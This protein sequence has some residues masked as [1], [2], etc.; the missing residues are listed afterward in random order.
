MDYNLKTGEELVSVDKNLAQILKPHQRDG[1]NFMWR[2]CFGS[3]TNICKND[4][5][6]RGCVLAHCMGLGQFH[7]IQVNRSESIVNRYF[8]TYNRQIAAN[9]YFGSHIIN[10]QKPHG[11]QQSLNF[12]SSGCYFKLDFPIPPLASKLSRN[13]RFQNP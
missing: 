2:R 5:L 11:S 8:S 13:T 4:D 1:V 12:M 9:N 6:V 3:V 7:A 10:A